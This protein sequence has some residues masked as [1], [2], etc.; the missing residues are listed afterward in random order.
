MTKCRLDDCSNP[1]TG[2]QTYCTDRCRQRARKGSRALR[3]RRGQN[4]Q[5]LPW[6]GTPGLQGIGSGVHP[7]PAIGVLQKP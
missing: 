1:V 5:I 7:C 4:R 2:R 3:Y 6:K